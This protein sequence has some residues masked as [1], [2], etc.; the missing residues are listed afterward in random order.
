VQL[1]RMQEH[2]SEK[3]QSSTGPGR[4]GPTYLTPML[5]KPMN[6]VFHIPDIRIGEDALGIG[7]VIPQVLFP[8]VELANVL[9][10][11]F[12]T[13]PN[14]FHDQMSQ[15]IS[16]QTGFVAAHFCHRL[17]VPV[18][19]KGILH[20]GEQIP[21]TVVDLGSDRRRQKRFALIGIGEM[22]IEGQETVIGGDAA[23]E[24]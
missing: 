1:E 19:D 3:K 15:R 8:F 24:A 5:S 6:N 17:R 2:V 9:P 11:P 21:E 7:L 4:F 20:S 18:P 10:G 16:A 12:A 13:T 14:R 22:A 23:H